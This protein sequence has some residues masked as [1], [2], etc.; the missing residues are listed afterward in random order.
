MC[1]HKITVDTTMHNI[2]LHSDNDVHIITFKHNHRRSGQKLLTV[3][4][5][6][7]PVV[8]KVIPLR[9]PPALVWRLG[10]IE[11]QLL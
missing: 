4:A 11:M 10:I 6:E 3:T 8:C 7:V 9:I 1:L 5:I 2:A